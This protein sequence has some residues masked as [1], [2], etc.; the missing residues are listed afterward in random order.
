MVSPVRAVTFDLWNT[1]LTGIP[2]AVETRARFWRR[3]VNERGLDIDDKLIHR[4]LS[5][6]PARFDEEWRAGRH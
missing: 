1:L 6:L 3:V 5:T 4:T 2:G